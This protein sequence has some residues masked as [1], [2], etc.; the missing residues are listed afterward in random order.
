MKVLWCW[1]CKMGIPMLDGNEWELVWHAY[2]AATNHTRDSR[3]A[4]LAEYERLT[5]FKES[6]FN[7]L[8]H[9][10]ISHHGPPCPRCVRV[11]RTPVAFKCFECGLQVHEANRMQS[12]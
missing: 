3:P 10:R 2:R 7:A 4:A 6:N 12:L 1:R 8:F 11:L 5:G 9:H